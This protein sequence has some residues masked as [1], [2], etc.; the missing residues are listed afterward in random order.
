[1]T[2]VADTHVLFWFLTN[3]RRL[4]SRARR[5]L[6][7]AELG[8]VKVYVPVIALAELQ[9]ILERE[10]SRHSLSDFLVKLDA[11]E[12]FEVVD[13]TR[14]HV[15]RLRAL[16]AIPEMHDRLIVALTLEQDAK[17]LTADAAIEDS[18]LVDVVW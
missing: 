17:L 8:T 10:H 16:G 4:G 6:S 14:N 13:M 3:S 12:G 7:A 1:M 2:Y 15:E 18:H 11:S 9:F 5:I